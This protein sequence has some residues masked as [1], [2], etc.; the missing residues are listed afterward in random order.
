MGAQPEPISR[1]GD[2][3]IPLLIF[4]GV[5][6]Q[7][8]APEPREGSQLVHFSKALDA[9]AMEI[10]DTQVEESCQDLLGKET[11]S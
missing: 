9:V 7:G 1:A 11:G 8:Q 2:P 10:E 5:P 6:V 4:N 3:P